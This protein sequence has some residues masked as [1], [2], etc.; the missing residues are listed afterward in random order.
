MLRWVA[1]RSLCLFYRD[2]S[3]VGGGRP[4]PPK[5]RSASVKTSSRVGKRPELGIALRT[6]QK[7]PRIVIDDAG[8]VLYL[9]LD[10]EVIGYLA[11]TDVPGALEGVNCQ[12]NIFGG[13][14]LRGALEPP[15]YWIPR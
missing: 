9:G 8:V 4:S 6:V 1:R 3:A 15:R 2:R 10:Q 13:V 11:N 14:K 5:A 12:V 7:T